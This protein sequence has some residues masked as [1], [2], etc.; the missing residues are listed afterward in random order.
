MISELIQAD[1]LLVGVECA[2]WEELVDIAGEPLVRKGLVEPEYLL[3]VKKAVE[4]YGA[5]MVLVDDVAF[6]HGRP[7]DGVR[8][9]AMSLALL[10]TPV[11]LLDKR[12]KAA[13]MFAAVD[14]DSHLDLLKELAVLM[15]DD[16]FLALLLDGNDPH[17]IYQKIREVETEV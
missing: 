2:S 16:G 6:F 12:V 17:A 11:Y 5:Y 9:L 10:K 13:F 8:E 3:S 14:N 1:H 7:E 4:K 15:N